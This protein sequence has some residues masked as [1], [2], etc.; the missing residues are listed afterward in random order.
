MKVIK[1]GKLLLVEGVD[2]VKF[3]TS[4]LKFL[5]INQGIYIYS[6]DGK[7]N[8]RKIIPAVTKCRGF[9]K[10]RIM[11]IVQ[12]ADNDEGRAFQSICE[13]LRRATL[14]I[15]QKVNK[16]VGDDIRIGIFIM[17]GISTDGTLEDLCMATVSSHP[18]IPCIDKFFNCNKLKNTIPGHLSKAR[19]LTFLA[20]MPDL[21]N[22]VGLGAEKGYWDFRSSVLDDLKGYIENFR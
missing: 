22:S 11:G 16:F 15:P 20:S 8:F 14:P 6:V 1:S 19:A 2:D 10:V 3:F 18:I 9:D 21:V 4:L 12:D 13:Y 17:P 5:N 7:D